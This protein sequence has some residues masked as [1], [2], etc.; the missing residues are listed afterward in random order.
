MNKKIRWL[1]IAV[2]VAV[3][4]V[5]IIWIA[6]LKTEEGP[7]LENSAESTST[8]EVQISINEV[9]EETPVYET[10]E[11]E[12][13][14]EQVPAQVQE[15]VPPQTKPTA[16]PQKPKADGDY[17]NPDAPPTY[18]EEQ[19]VVTQPPKK[20]EPSKEQNTSQAPSGYVYID[21]FGYVPEAGEAQTQPGYSDGDINKQV[22]SMN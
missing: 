22:G 8:P 3:A 18:S 17:T 9:R 20:Q 2:G 19:T 1:L 11:D 14:G 15:N 16:P 10:I 7:T 5:L 4:A 13:T 21:G 6:S 12:E